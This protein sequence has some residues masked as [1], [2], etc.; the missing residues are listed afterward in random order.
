MPP[1]TFVDAAMLVHCGTEV[2]HPQFGENGIKA[3]A[4]VGVGGGILFYVLLFE[5]DF[6]D[7]GISL[8]FCHIPVAAG[9]ETG[10]LPDLLKKEPDDFAVDLVDT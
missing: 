3:A 7:E 5:K 10:F 1:F 2:V 6:T 9:E 8:Q 4:G